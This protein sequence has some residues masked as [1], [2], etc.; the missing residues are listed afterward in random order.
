MAGPTIPIPVWFWRD[1]DTYFGFGA[2]SE[3]PGEAPVTL[4]W[5]G[6]ARA[7][8][9]MNF[10]ASA[11]QMVTPQQLDYEVLGLGDTDDFTP[12]PAAAL[13]PAYSWSVPIY[14]LRLE[15]RVQGADPA[16]PPVLG[17]WARLDDPLPDEIDAMGIH[18]TEASLATIKD[19]LAAFIARTAGGQPDVSKVQDAI[20]R[21]Q[22]ALTAG[23]TFY[24]TIP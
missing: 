6:A 17:A 23:G 13:P 14:L 1:Q 15:C 19:S 21:L 11:A 5:N 20:I 22:R 18:T 4:F 7:D 10:F 12:S 16:A 9:L 8:D 24:S 2:Q 3:R